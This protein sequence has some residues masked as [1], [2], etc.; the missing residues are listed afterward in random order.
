MER[1]LHRNTQNKILGGVC[2]GLAEYFDIDPVLVRLLFVLFTFQGGLGILA[3]IILWIVVPAKKLEPAFVAASDA[4]APIMPAPRPVTPPEV[5][6][7]RATVAG[8][9]LII[10]G[11]IFLADNLIPAFHFG[12]LWPVLFIVVGGG[13]LWNA[14]TEKQTQETLS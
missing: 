4:S 14:M 11:A 5:K 3:Y 2:S 1:R 6:A 12:D 9:I 8:T 10:A 13:L 7:K